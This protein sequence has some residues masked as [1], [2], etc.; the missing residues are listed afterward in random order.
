V[1]VEYFMNGFIIWYVCV[2]IFSIPSGYVFFPM[3]FIFLKFCF[4]CDLNV[5]LS[6]EKQ[7]GRLGNNEEEKSMSYL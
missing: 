1:E 6:K 2:F 7:T 3:A 5:A 4:G